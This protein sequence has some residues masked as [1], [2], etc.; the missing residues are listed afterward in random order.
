MATRCALRLRAGSKIS[1]VIIA[2]HGLFGD[3]RGYMR[4]EAGSTTIV[5]TLAGFTPEGSPIAESEVPE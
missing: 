2:Q 4:A 1:Q 5:A 3:V